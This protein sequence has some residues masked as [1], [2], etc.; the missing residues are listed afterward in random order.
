M[1][2][3]AQPSEVLALTFTVKAAEEMRGRMEKNVGW[4]KSAGIHISN[5]HSL[6]LVKNIISQFAQFGGLISRFV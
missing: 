3:G 6:A 2:M 5:F 1:Q 4:I